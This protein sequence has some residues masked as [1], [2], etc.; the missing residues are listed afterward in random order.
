MAH[1]LGDPR[2]VGRALSGLSVGAPTPHERRP[3][4][5]D[6][7]ACFRQAGDTYYSIP[8]LWELAILEEQRGRLGTAGDLYREAVV[9]SEQITSPIDLNW[10]WTG[11]CFVLFRQGEFDEASLTARKSLIGGRRLGHRRTVA[12][13][14]FVLAC[15]AT[16]IG[17]SHRAAQL[18]GAHEIL[19]ADLLAAA[20]DRAYPFGSDRHQARTDNEARLRQLLGPDDFERAYEIGARLD[21]EDAVDLALDRTHQRVTRDNS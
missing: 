1:R 17:D 20:G 10:S 11:L 9:A 15:C 18:T 4:H 21:F 19:R 5:R 13:A 16:S 3:L 7:I 2:L 8:E 12:F 14:T 6:A